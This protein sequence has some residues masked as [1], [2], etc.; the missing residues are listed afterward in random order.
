MLYLP[1][2]ARWV[3]T[4]IGV[5]ITLVGLA[6]ALNSALKLSNDLGFASED[7]WGAFIGVVVL[8]IGVFTMLV[9][10][11]QSPPRGPPES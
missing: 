9:T 8:V 2:K 7:F 10:W 5:I 3:L 1:D 4:G 11:Y 6:I